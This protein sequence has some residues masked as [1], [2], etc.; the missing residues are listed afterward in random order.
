MTG[1]FI[2]FE[3][4]DGSGKS[5]QAARLAEWLNSE[6]HEIVTTFEPG[7]TALGAV[8]RDLV[9]HSTTI[10]ISPKAEA[11]L[12]A[13]DKAQHIAEVVQPA[14]EGG[15]IVI[16]DRY[17]DS[18]IAYQ[19]AGRVLDPAEITRLAHWSVSDLLPDL[20]VLMDVPVAQAMDGKGSLDRIE[21]AGPAFHERVRSYFLALA[22]QDPGRYLIVNGRDPK[23]DVTAVIRA[24]VAQLL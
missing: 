5:T 10:P 11:L 17:I 2:C 14:L 21:S 6:G 12:Y 22:A 1:I 15:K 13:A 20:T 16:S 7:D 23:D 24:R 3:G 9:L 19:G 4:G 18:T 8:M